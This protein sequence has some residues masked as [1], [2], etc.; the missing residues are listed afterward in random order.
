V[1][2]WGGIGGLAAAS[3]PGLTIAAAGTAAFVAAQRRVR[4]PKL[5]LPP[6]WPHLSHAARHA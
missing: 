1:G 6:G 4:S 2:L 5:P 3:G